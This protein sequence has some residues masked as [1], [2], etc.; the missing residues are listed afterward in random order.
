MPQDSTTP[1]NQNRRWPIPSTSADCSAVLARSRAVPNRATQQATPQPR[2][3]PNAATRPWLPLRAQTAPRH[4]YSH[5]IE[6][7]QLHSSI[8]THA[9]ALLPTNAIKTTRLTAPT[10]TYCSAAKR[11]VQRKLGQRPRRPPL[12][13]KRPRRQQSAEWRHGAGSDDRDSVRGCGKHTRGVESACTQAPDRAAH[14]VAP[15]EVAQR[16][17]GHR[18]NVGRLRREPRDER[19]HDASARHRELVRVCQTRTRAHTSPQPVWSASPR[20]CHFVRGSAA[21][22]PPGAARQPTSMQAAR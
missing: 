22:Q 10:G 18:L 4:R 13:V 3:N 21:L 16:A 2:D 12:H 11:T 9:L 17:R 14:T 5:E 15:S 7:K 8:A 19:A 1:L 6:P 20:T